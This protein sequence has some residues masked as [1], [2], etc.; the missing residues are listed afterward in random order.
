M[1]PPLDHYEFERWR[2]QA[3]RALDAA[4]LVR[5]RPEW[6]CFLSEQAA[7]LAVK[8]LLHGIGEGAWG[9]DLTVLVARAAAA[10]E[11]AWDPG[12]GNVAA[13]LSRHYI[14]TRY[15]DAHPTGPPG[16]HYTDL[17]AEQAL[18]D[19]RLVLETVGVAWQTVQGTD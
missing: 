3:S 4:E 7:Q 8:A 1:T 17:D 11:E 13:R 6:A 14:P 5:G 15:P 9:H 18:A 12:L 16:A 19:A 2:E 10:L